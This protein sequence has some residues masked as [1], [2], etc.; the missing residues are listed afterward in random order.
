M[1]CISFKLIIGLTPEHYKDT[2]SAGVH[3]TRTFTRKL[4]THLFCFVY[5]SS[6]QHVLGALAIYETIGG[7][8][9]LCRFHIT[10]SRL[11]ITR[12][13]YNNAM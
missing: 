3:D 11:K 6:A 10:T 2:S 1:H 13:L 4:G 12:V 5:Q 8:H 9:R 7:V